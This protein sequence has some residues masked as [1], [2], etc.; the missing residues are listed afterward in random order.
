MRSTSPPVIPAGAC[1]PQASI[2]PN[3]DRGRFDTFGAVPDSLGLW[4]GFRGVGSQP[5][6]T[7]NTFA[8]SEIS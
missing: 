1:E 4:V 8:S 2:A 3:R 5:H 7:M 6:S